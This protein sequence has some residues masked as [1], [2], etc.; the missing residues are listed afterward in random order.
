MQVF[1]NQ[2]FVV[3]MVLFSLGY[4]RFVVAE[5]D[6]GTYFSLGFG[7][8]LSAKTTF[9]DVKTAS[10]NPAALFGTD[11]TTAR[12]DFGSSELFE[13]ALGYRFTSMVRAE[14]AYGNTPGFEF[15][16]NARFYNSGD[17]QPVSADLSSQYVSINTYLDFPE[18]KFSDNFRLQPYL[19]TGFGRSRNKISKVTYSFPE[20][21]MGAGGEQAVSVTPAG[22]STR[23]VYQIIAGLSY[24]FG[25]SYHLSLQYRYA[26]LGDVTTDVGPLR[27]VR[28]NEDGTTN[29]DFDVQINK[30]V[31]QLKIHSWQLN[32]RYLW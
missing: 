4:S 12:G 11:E 14:V 28:Y 8:F 7:T 5:E 18:I 17:S 24:P 20:F 31:A 15:Q 26:S 29:R 9:E 6:S 30:T 32:I 16:G 25:K 23:N 22:S 21:N 2:I 10:V 3:L 1:K 13:G 19:G 27:I